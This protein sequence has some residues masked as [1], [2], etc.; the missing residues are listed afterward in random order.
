M[1]WIAKKVACAALALLAAGACADL[2]K[3]AFPMAKFVPDQFVFDNQVGLFKGKYHTGV[4]FAGA[5]DA[6]ILA[7]NFGK[8]EVVVPVG[9]KDFG[10]GNCVILSHLLPD[11]N[12]LYSLYGHLSRINEDIKPG[13]WVAQGHPV[14][15]VGGS[16]W[17]EL[18]KY[19]IH[20]HF[21]FKTA[22]VLG[23]PK[24]PAGKEQEVWFGYQ[25]TPSEEW[26]YLDPY[27][28]IGKVEALSFDEV[29]RGSGKQPLYWAEYD[30]LGGPSGFGVASGDVQR[31]GPT[32]QTVRYQRFTLPGKPDRLLA[33]GNT[34]VYAI[35]GP[36]VEAFLAADIATLG[37]PLQGEHDAERSKAGTTG[38]IM[39]FE[40]GALVWSAKHGGFAVTGV[41]WERY[42]RFQTTAGKFGFP[43]ASPSGGKQA[44]EGGSLPAE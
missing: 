41:T 29:G 27:K 33:E 17:G 10:L 1:K 2:K 26:G 8:V 20:V 24:K 44:F 40:K 3:F 11:G 12:K 37:S 35:S 5:K 30:R 6:Q 15:I 13:V 22:P 16:A 31:K 42:Q 36:M 39:E 7:V 34:G 38:R 25:S 21:E 14:G 9:P 4:D 43:K 32:G 23:S 19:P 28:I 18:N